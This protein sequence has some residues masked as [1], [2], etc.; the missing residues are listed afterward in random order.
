M[1]KNTNRGGYD[2]TTHSSLPV[3]DAACRLHET[4]RGNGFSGND[5]CGILFFGDSRR[6]RNGGNRD[7]DR[8]NGNGK[9]ENRASANRA[10]VREQRQSCRGARDH[11]GSGGKGVYL[12]LRVPV[13]DLARHNHVLLHGHAA[14]GQRHGRHAKGK[15]GRDSLCHK[16]K[17]AVGVGERDRGEHR[18]DRGRHR[19]SHPARRDLLH[20]GV[21]GIRVCFN[22]RF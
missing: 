22:G 17:P 20:R 9:R 15:A 14:Y 16:H 21:S 8:R 10:C 7:K 18:A 5:R 4:D 11:A 2:E 1:D 19:H 13:S 12:R 3:R 6:N